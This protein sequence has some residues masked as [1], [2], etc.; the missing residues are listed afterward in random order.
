MDGLKYALTT[1]ITAPLIGAMT[2]AAGTLRTQ[3]TAGPSMTTTSLPETC[4]AHAVAAT[5]S[6]PTSATDTK[7]ATT[8]TLTGRT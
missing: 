1:P 4:A 6:A 3:A 5:E 8:P 2:D 7:T